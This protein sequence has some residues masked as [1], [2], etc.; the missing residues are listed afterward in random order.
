MYSTKRVVYSVTILLLMTI[1]MKVSGETAI[2]Q[3][4]S[5]FLFKG[6]GFLCFPLRD[7][8]N[9]DSNVLT[10]DVDGD[11]CGG[12]DAVCVK[13]AEES[14]LCAAVGAGG[15]Q[16]GCTTSRDCKLG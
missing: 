14:I 10:C 1:G 15:A 8:C 3:E 2:E 6:E 9:D 4:R 11:L 13:T 5:S 7:G 12:G 16:S